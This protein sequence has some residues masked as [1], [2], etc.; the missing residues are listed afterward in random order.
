MQVGE[1]PNNPVLSIIATTVHKQQSLLHSSNKSSTI[2][3][4]PLLIPSLFPPHCTIKGGSYSELKSN[5]ASGSSFLRGQQ[6]MV[7]QHFLAELN[8]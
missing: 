8:V 2:P 3:P 5:Q 7:I 1:E 6:A 4:P